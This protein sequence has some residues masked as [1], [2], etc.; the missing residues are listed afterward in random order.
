MSLQEQCREAIY[1]Y[2]DEETQMNASLFGEHADYVKMVIQILRAEYIA[3]Q[4]AGATAFTI[5]DNI[6]LLLQ[7]ECPW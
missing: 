1:N 2:V 6:A 3:Q 5:P 4:D 7:E